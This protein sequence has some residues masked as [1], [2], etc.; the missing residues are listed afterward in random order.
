M[1]QV[2]WFPGTNFRINDPRSDETPFKNFGVVYRVGCGQSN[3]WISL[4]E[5][6]TNVLQNF[7]VSYYGKAEWS[8]TA[9]TVKHAPCLEYG[10][11]G[12][13]RVF[14]YRNQENA[15]TNLKSS[16]GSPTRDEGRS[17]VSRPEQ[18]VGGDKK[19][20]GNDFWKSSGKLPVLPKWHNEESAVTLETQRHGCT[21]TTA[22]ATSALNATCAT[23]SQWE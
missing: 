1:L 23:W 6:V 17:W 21:S 20:L 5:A 11:N 7:N 13:G 22:S 14:E 19:T 18:G 4:L 10:Q 8:G 2:L 16:H 15:T 12:Q 9:R 3:S